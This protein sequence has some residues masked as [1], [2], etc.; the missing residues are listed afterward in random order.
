M[1]NKGLMLLLSYCSVLCGGVVIV[2]VC[3]S[4]Y[5]IVSLVRLYI[6]IVQIV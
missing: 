6:Q 3:T 2:N 1:P 5:H 4:N